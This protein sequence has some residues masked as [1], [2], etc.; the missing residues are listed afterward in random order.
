MET[1]VFKKLKADHQKVKKLFSKIGETENKD[2]KER[3][4]LFSE[5][6]TE[7]L[8]HAK[9]EENVFYP[10]L[11]LEESTRDLTLEAEVEHQVAESL[12]RQLDEEDCATDE[13][14]AKCKVLEEVVKH[15]IKEE[16]EEIFPKAK[17]MIDAERSQELAIII[18]QEE[19]SFKEAM[20]A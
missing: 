14:A 6:Q 20:I 9:A 13:W 2:A 16:E 1:D 10:N 11:K 15:H 3:E 18:E 4:E 7:L 5:L 12:L 19:E 17:K 8:A